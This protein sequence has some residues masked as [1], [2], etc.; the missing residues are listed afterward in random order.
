MSREQEQ[1]PFVNQQGEEAEE[2]DFE[3]LAPLLVAKL[4][5][6]CNYSSV[7]LVWFTENDFGNRKRVSLRKI[8]K[9]F[10][11]RVSTLWKQLRLRP[12]RLYARSRG[13]ASKKRTRFLRK[14]GML[15]SRR[16]GC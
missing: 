15:L 14:V 12:R 3:S 11:M 10:Q 9:S 16:D 13:S 8:R 6:R 2:E 7:F 4:Q 1:D 5:V